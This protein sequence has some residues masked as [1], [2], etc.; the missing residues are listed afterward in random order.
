M[1]RSSVTYHIEHI[2]SFK[3]KLII[4]CSKFKYYSVL[5]GDTDKSQGMYLKK[6]MIVGVDS[7]SSIS[8]SKNS[9][10]ELKYFYDIKKDWLFGAFSYDLKNEIEDLKSENQDQHQFPNLVFF[11]PKWVFEIIGNNISIYYPSQLERSQMRLIFK[12]IMTQKTEEVL[13]KHAPTLNQRITKDQYLN[14]FEKI[15]EHIDRG[16]IYEMN[17]CFEYF[18]QNV[19]LNTFSIYK[20]LFAISKPPFSAYFR[21]DDHHLICA[22]PERYVK[23]IGTKIISQPIKGTKKRGE[24]LEE[25]EALKKELY[26]CS[27]E[28]SENVMI[29]DLVRNDLS[30]F[31]EKGSVK[32]DELYNV[33]S[34]KQVHHLISTISCNLKS[35]THWVDV[36]KDTFP[37]GS[38]TGAPKIMAMKLIE[39]YEKTK[40]GLYSG[41]VGYVTPDGDFDFN[42]VIR[43]IIFSKSKRFASFMVG[44]ALTSKSDPL[45]EY[46]ECELKAHA[47]LKVLCI[48]D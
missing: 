31:S 35:N 4:W 36:I 42:V 44:S 38:M 7:L 11:Q 34:F 48:T 30:K 18:A 27:K 10:Q 45:K 6:D 15:I 9:L 17:Y 24:T 12:Q 40:R 3:E 21:T 33:Y 43:S 32:V 19:D 26:N 1:K 28:R 25:D 13:I 29:V 39:K 8:S 22:S 5:K 46:S 16:D 37:M 23:K 41:S 2:E 47:M 14:Q 20:D